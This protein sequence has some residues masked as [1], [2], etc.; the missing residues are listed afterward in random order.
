V[1]A[2]AT[3]AAGPAVGE[4]A[5]AWLEIGAVRVRHRVPRAPELVPPLSA[6]GGAQ[7]LA[8]HEADAGAAG[9]LGTDTVAAL[10][11]LMRKD[12]LGQDVF[13]LGPPGP[14]R[15]R[16]ALLYAALTG[17]E[18]EY[19]ALSR[20][21]TE[22]D[23]RQRR[24]VRGDALRLADQAAVRAA[25]HGR[26]LVLDGIERA[27]RNVLPTLNN[28][29][30]SR[31]LT[32]DD[33]RHLLP[34]ARYDAAVARARQG[35]AGPEG[36]GSFVRVSPDFRVVALGLPCPPYE[37]APLDP[38]FRSRFQ[39]R[40]LEP[41]GDHAHA[42]AALR[43]LAPSVPA[44]ELHALLTV[45]ATLQ[46]AARPRAAATS[47]ESGSTSSTNVVMRTSS[48]V[49]AAGTP[50]GLG[51]AVTA[52]LLSADRVPPLP[53]GAAAS[54]AWARHTLPAEPLASSWR[55]TYPFALS[56]SAAAQLDTLLRRQGLL[57]ADGA[58]TALP[59][60]APSAGY[61]VDEAVPVARVPDDPDRAEVVLTPLPAPAG[62]AAV[63]RLQVPAGPLPVGGTLPR[64]VATDYHTAA[65]AQMVIAHARGDLCVHGPRGV[66]KT[67]VVARFAALLGYPLAYVAVYRDMSARDLLLRRSV[68]GSSGEGGGGR[69]TVWVRS[70]LVTAALHGHLA[71]LDGVEQLAPGTLASLQA[72]LSDRFLALPDGT[73]LLS[74]P[75]YE[76]ARRA[77]A[78]A[79]GAA[80]VPDAELEARGLLRIHPSFRVVAM[81]GPV[82]TRATSTT[83]SGGAGGSG[84]SVPIPGAGRGPGTTAAWCTDEVATLFQFVEFRPLSEAEEA[85]LLAHAT[86]CPPDVSAS[87]LRFAHHRTTAPGPTMASASTP[88]LS[89]RQLLRIARRLAAY[90]G[91]HVRTAI[92]AATLAPFLPPLARAALAQRLDDAGVPPEP[93]I[94]GPPVAPF[95]VEGDTEARTL[96]IGQARARVHPLPTDAT[97]ALVPAPVFFDSP[98]HTAALEDML[99]DWVLGEP[100]LLVGPQGVG[101][102][103]LADRLCALLQR[104]R[105]YVQLHRDSTVE[106]L[107][108]R[109]RVADGRIVYDD[110]PLVKAAR[111]GHVL[112]VDEADKA[113]VHVTAVLRTLAERGQMGLPDGRYIAPV[114][115]A[116]T[117]TAAAGGGETKDPWWI[118]LHPEFRLMVLAN[119]PGFPFHGNDFYGVLGDAL[120]PHP[121]D[122]PAPASELALL[123]RVAPS[124]PR[125]LLQRL[126]GVFADLRAACADG[127]LAYPYSLREL[128]AIARHLE[129]WP[130]D[131]LVTALR[132]VFDFDACTPDLEPLLLRLLRRH[133]FPLASLRPDAN[134]DTAAAGASGGL[135]QLALHQPLPPPHVLGPVGVWKRG[136]VEVRA[137]TVDEEDIRVVGGPGDRVVLE[138]DRVGAGASAG[139]GS[140]PS[141]LGTSGGS[142]VPHWNARLHRFTEQV[143]AFQLPGFHRQARI[144]AVAAGA[145]DPDDRSDADA[146]EAERD[147][148]RGALGQAVLHVLTADP[149]IL[150]TYRLSAAGLPVT[151]TATSLNPIVPWGRLA[152]PV[153]A[154]V[155]GRTGVLTLYASAANV[156]AHIDVDAARARTVRLPAH[157][158]TAPTP[159]SAASALLRALGAG[160]PDGA[161]GQSVGGGGAAPMA[162]S[163]MHV[164][165]D[166]HGV[167]VAAVLAPAASRTAPVW[168][169][170]A[171]QRD[172]VRRVAGGAGYVLGTPLEGDLALGRA[173]RWTVGPRAGWHRRDAMAARPMTLVLDAGAAPLAAT[174][175]VVGAV[176][177]LPAMRASPVPLDAVT[178]AEDTATALLETDAAGLT[179]MAAVPLAASADPG[180]SVAVHYA[181][182]PPAARPLR[183][184]APLVCAAQPLV[185][186]AQAAAAAEGDALVA[187][188]E[189]VDL[190]GGTV[191][192]IPL[193]PPPSSLSQ[194]GAAAGTAPLAYTVAEVP[195]G[196]SSSLVAAV[197]ADGLITLWQLDPEALA[198]DAATWLRWVHGDSDAEGG[199]GRRRL[200]VRHVRGGGPRGA[201]RASA[202]QSAA[203]RLAGPKH[204][205]W[206]GKEHHGGGTFAGG[207]GGR[208]TAGL[209]GRG[210]PYRLD[211]GYDVHQ[212]DDEVKEAVP[213]EVRRAAKMMA[214]QALADRLHEIGLTNEQGDAYARMVA[215]VER[216]LRQVRTLFQRAQARQRERVWL[217]HQTD[218]DLDERRLVDALTGESTVFRR[219]ADD[220]GTHGLVQ[221][222]PKR[223]CFVF[224]LSGSMYR[225]DGVDGRLARETEAAV[226][227]MEALAGTDPRRLQYEMVGHS[228]DSA[229]I[230]LV[231]AGQPPAHEG[232]RWQVVQRMIAHTQYC[233]SGDNTLEALASAIAA[234][235]PVPADEHIVVLLSDANLG[236]YAIGADE[237]RTAME[238]DP[239]V[240]TYVIF[241]GSLGEQAQRLVEQLPAGRAFLCMDP[242]TLPAVFQHILAHSART[243]AV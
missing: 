12:A 139:A 175:V 27:E 156:L 190:D 101:K 95:V 146:A 220:P 132:D 138:Q 149:A 102:N 112:I 7:A 46:L 29:L 68:E 72:L 210:G 96:V 83:A 119:R 126:V 225:F 1:R 42:H 78:H 169:M 131:P 88:T 148:T 202:G 174:A 90:P 230:P 235:A 187:R 54:L 144:V 85:G 214:A 111:A 60:A 189:V 140:G 71:V 94:A 40:Y 186:T 142:D 136:D 212:V 74:A 121:I 193:P 108:M 239:R 81:A 153:H 198:T 67:T 20:D 182:G 21:T 157:A 228:G 205:K 98:Q 204:G 47:T 2:L 137:G 49:A 53:E 165:R 113:P 243:P 4:E 16:L 82:D 199:G 127:T 114:P 9:P 32:L 19:V 208:D 99:K 134:P 11:W 242:S 84:G 155:L 36:S 201:E 75:A 15:R 25:V 24:E 41:E 185:V 194:A 195:V 168:A 227:L 206:D 44:S 213:E 129:A 236:R 218:G 224:D 80:T 73:R 110:T 107:G 217:G 183:L 3:G 91:D 231:P 143:A 116:A 125:S 65:L 35:D 70:P 234:L 92:E 151:Y 219:R 162:G 171:V 69:T 117:A 152:A 63:V 240:A 8:P 170:D 237:M 106:S 128:V 76:A 120:A 180:P 79:Q 232:A 118:P 222:H 43:R 100:L 31:E 192:H 177:G 141:A 196:S 150:H 58:V 124:V 109:A 215:A 238:R 66:G 161:S 163:S 226:L 104:P 130:A 191:A 55:R 179:L 221:T 178:H 5:G 197:R 164:H 56:P 87:L 45:A 211:A 10:A 33:G 154:A 203:Q 223:L 172:T 241:I 122:N 105:E 188:L 13:L 23:L 6:D 147:G 34:P 86:G 167:G 52:S 18:I 200:R 159:T 133:G 22:A 184:S 30:E 48:A 173:P 166:R 64:W 176:R 39:S 233:S 62:T 17:R 229:A 14:A 209:G 115:A 103:K 97:A 37:G 93:T 160:G 145:L 123:A 28:L 38:P 135:V 207:T 61:R 59:R 50:G 77:L 89:T 216:P 51:A 181:Y 57:A 158:D 26:L